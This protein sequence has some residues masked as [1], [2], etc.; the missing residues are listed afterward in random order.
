MTPP[1]QVAAV[2]GIGEIVPGDELGSILAPHFGDLAWPDGTSGLAD[3]DIVV[4][5]SKVVSKAEGRLVPVADRDAAIAAETVDVV[6]VKTTPRGDTRIVRTRHGLVLAA[7]G[8]DNSNAPDG[9][10]LLLPTDPDASARAIRERIHILTGRSVAVVI[11]D[12]LGRPGS[13]PST[14]TVVGPTLPGA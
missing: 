1:L 14:T 10:V 7:A 3:G 6:A 8:V 4:I 11:T 2:T 13:P 5:T 12:T 9:T